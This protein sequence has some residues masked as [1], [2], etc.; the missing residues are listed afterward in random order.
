VRF[1]SILSRR[2]PSVRRSKHAW[3]AAFALPLLAVASS[4]FPTATVANNLPETSEK[5]TTPAPENDRGWFR[6]NQ[7]NITVKQHPDADLVFIGD[8]ITQG[9]D[10]EC[11]R[12]GHN[13]W[14]KYYGK[15]R[16]VNLGSGGD[17]TQHVLWRLDHGN[18]DGLHFKLAVLLIGTNNA[19][20]CTPDETRDGV[21]AIVE[22]LRARV[23][24]C[25][26][27]VLGI[28]PRGRD[29]NNRLRK[30]N[31]AANK[32]IKKLADGKHV[33]YLDIGPK[34]LDPDGTIS[35]FIMPDFLHLNEQGY[36]IWASAIE[37]EVARLLGERR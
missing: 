10:Y 31:E 29:A 15:R 20:T 9:W 8:S 16:A 22:K 24:G 18:L 35:P 28:L 23:P 30:V 14:L 5:S 25:K 2:G 12:W 33:F 11:P 37:P 17:K 32:K 19:A 27:L 6:H 26:V 13:V 21:R 34:F 7:L 4:V 36:E 1:L 3:F